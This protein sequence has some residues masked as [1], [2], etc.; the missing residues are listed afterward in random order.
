MH[1]SVRFAG[2][3][4]QGLLTAGFILAEAAGIY[5]GKYISQTQAY[6]AEARG[7]TSRADVIVSD[8]PIVYPKPIKLDILVA[9]NQMALDKFSSALVKGGYL[10]ADSTYVKN[11]H[12]TEGLL[13]P[14]TEMARN[15]IGNVVV[16]NVIALGAMTELTS[17]VSKKAIEQAVADRVPKQH[18][19]VNIKALEMGFEAGKN[20][21]DIQK[22]AEDDLQIV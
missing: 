1:V 14:F 16:A 13:I 8:E 20:V 11:L 15:E 9:M 6:G 19:K 21:L 17:I 5:D 10:L 18:K 2:F 4:G 7:G 22:K 3:G 12:I